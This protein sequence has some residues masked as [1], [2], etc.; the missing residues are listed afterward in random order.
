MCQL[1]RDLDYASMFCM[2]VCLHECIHTH[3]YMRAHEYVPFKRDLE[4]MC[5]YIHTHTHTYIYIYICA[6]AHPA[7]TYN[8]M[9]ITLADIHVRIRCQSCTYI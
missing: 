9:Y 7:H 5:V 1:T 3:T 8:S 6:I 2:H 4:S